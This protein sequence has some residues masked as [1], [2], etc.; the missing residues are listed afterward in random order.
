MR[1]KK[2]EGGRRRETARKRSK[3]ERAMA[4]HLSVERVHVGKEDYSYFSQQT[5]CILTK[6]LAKV[7]QAS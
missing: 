5:S 7:L 3:A 4:E 2:K 6:M 1:E